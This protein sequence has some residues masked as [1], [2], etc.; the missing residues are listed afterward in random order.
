M[1][2]RALAGRDAVADVRTIEPGDDQPVARDPEL[3]I[4]D[5]PLDGAHVGREALERAIARQVGPRGRAM[6]LLTQDEALAMRL[7]TKV[8]RLDRGRLAEG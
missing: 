5:E 3:V 6:L 1:L 7:C 8:L 4:L 2:R